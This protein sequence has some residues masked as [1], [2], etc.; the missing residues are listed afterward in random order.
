MS[1]RI[2]CVS[3]Q[4]SIRTTKTEFQTSGDVGEKGRKGSGQGSKWTPGVAPCQASTPPPWDEML[5]PWVTLTA[6]CCVSTSSSLFLLLFLAV[7]NLWTGKVR[8]SLLAPVAPLKSG[9]HSARLCSACSG[10]FNLVS[11]LVLDGWAC[12]K[13]VF[14]GPDVLS[15]GELPTRVPSCGTFFP[16]TFCSLR[17]PCF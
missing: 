6:T 5:Q 2:F 15:K 13:A 11:P 12:W 17:F 4:R 1:W 7:S 10:Y 3:T 9:K 14:H 8:W 16:L